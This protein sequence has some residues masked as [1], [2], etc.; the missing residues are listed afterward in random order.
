MVFSKYFYD[1]EEDEKHQKCLQIIGK[2]F[3]EDVKLLIKEVQE[4]SDKSQCGT[5]TFND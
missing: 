5:I 1:D 3:K 4:V 2:F